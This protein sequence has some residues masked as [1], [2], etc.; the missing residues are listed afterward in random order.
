MS[1]L[2]A[3]ATTCFPWVCGLVAPVMLITMIGCNGSNATGRELPG[4]IKG[5]VTYK[6]A[7]VKNAAISFVGISEQ[8]AFGGPLAEDGTYQVPEAAV[9]DFQ[10]AILPISPQT[11][12]T[13]NPEGKIA[14]PPERNDIPKKYRD[15]KTSGLT[16]N[17]IDGDNEFSVDMVD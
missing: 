12:M 2:R 5:V 17:V 1:V 15:T 10:I 6:G 11:T 4:R 9:G 13:M 3:S 8:G 16:L 7:P 14:A